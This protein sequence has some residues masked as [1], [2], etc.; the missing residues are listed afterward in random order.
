MAK[1]SERIKITLECTEARELGASP[2][3]YVT[4]KNRRQT[5]GRLELKK[6]SPSLRRR[7]VHREIK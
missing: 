6:Y 3:R 1:K 7:T 2:S 5:P 4:T